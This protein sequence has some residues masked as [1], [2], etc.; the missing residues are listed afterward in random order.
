MSGGAYKFSPSVTRCDH[1]ASGGHRGLILWYTGLSGSGKSTLANAVAR[2]LH[3]QGVRTFILDGDNLRNGLN[4][5]LGFSKDGREENIRRV[6]EVARLFLEC[7]VVVSACLIS[8][9]Q[10]AR[11]R[12][13]QSVPAGDYVEI[14][15]RASIEQC[16]SR[17]TKGLYARARAGQV[18]D[19][20][21]ISSPYEPPANAE[22]V[23]D[24]G[25]ITVQQAVGQVLEYLGGRGIG[26]AI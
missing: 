26:R 9:F 2:A 13:R 17:D 8:P 23:V 20:T 21:G 11:D 4:S 1:E 6:Q 22:L 12:L 18:Q 25:E 7:G 14:Y 10:A 5:D 3:D 16:E 24:T 15:C 19:F